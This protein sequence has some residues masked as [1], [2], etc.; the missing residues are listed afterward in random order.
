MSSCTADMIA[1]GQPVSVTV[2]GREVGGDF[3][4]VA[5]PARLLE[6]PAPRRPQPGDDVK[7]TVTRRTTKKRCVS[8]MGTP[9][10]DTARLFPLRSTGRGK[11]K[12]INLRSSRQ[13]RR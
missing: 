13:P 7:R 2:T 11:S 10:N 8:V 6:A 4:A 12:G 9:A 5:V 1:D 3:A